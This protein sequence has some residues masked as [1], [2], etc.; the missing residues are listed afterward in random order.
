VSE[1][2]KVRINQGFRINFDAVNYVNENKRLMERLDK[3]AANR[4]KAVTDEVRNAAK[5][6][7]ISGARRLAVQHERVFEGTYIEGLKV[8]IARGFSSDH[9]V[10]SIV[11][12]N[13]FD[14]YDPMK[15]YAQYLED[16]M[17]PGTT[18]DLE[19]LTK[20][21]KKKK[22]LG[23]GQAHREALKVQKLLYKRGYKGSKI[24]ETAYNEG[25]PDFSREFREIIKVLAL[26]SPTA[27]K[28]SKKGKGAKD[29]FVDVPF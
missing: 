22:N 4:Y 11:S 1:S 28:K 5:A 19:R 13:T 2:K 25:D 24:M 16:D 17:P 18:Q 27:K 29:T 9:A 15:S 3:L 12:D 7:F 23:D 10:I 26:E 8:V 14:S 21:V 20:W 6:I